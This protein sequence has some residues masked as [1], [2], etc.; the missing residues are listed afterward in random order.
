MQKYKIYKL[1]NTQYCI[2]L[3]GQLLIFFS[4]RIKTLQN[5]ILTITK[6]SPTVFFSVKN[7]T[8]NLQKNQNDFTTFCDRT[9]IQFV[10]STIGRISTIISS[11]LPHT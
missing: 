8:K 4:R 9:F 7:K 3:I 11:F 6:F 2:T 1:L 5:N 10:Y